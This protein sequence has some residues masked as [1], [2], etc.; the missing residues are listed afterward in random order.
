[1]R[2]TETVGSD[3]EQVMNSG[4]VCE[5]WVAVKRRRA[6]KKHSHDEASSSPRHVKLA[7]AALTFRSFSSR[8]LHW[9]YYPPN[10]VLRGRD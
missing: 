7:Q 2:S 6:L 5:L 8:G 3:C 4:A 1:M 10:F 9:P